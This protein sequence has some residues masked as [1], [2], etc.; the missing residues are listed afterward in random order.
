MDD[1]LRAVR[2]GLMHGRNYQHL[3]DDERFDARQAD[4]EK[5]QKARQALVDI[6]D[7]HAELPR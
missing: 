1:A 3:A 2:I 6:T 7:L 5:L 4:L